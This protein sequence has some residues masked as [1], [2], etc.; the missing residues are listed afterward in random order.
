MYN[1]RTNAK[2]AAPGKDELWRPW[3]RQ[4]KFFYSGSAADP[5]W[6]STMGGEDFSSRGDDY[7]KNTARC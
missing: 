2:D 1:T 5:C 4:G 7:G 6:R 3:H